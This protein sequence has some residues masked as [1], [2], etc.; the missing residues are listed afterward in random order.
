MG[1]RGSLPR[2][3]ALD[4][5][6]STPGGRVGADASGTVVL[7]GPGNVTI[8][9]RFRRTSNRNWTIEVNGGS[10]SL[11]GVTLTA[12]DFSGRLV[13]VGG[14][15]VGSVRLN[16]SRFPK[17]VSGWGQSSVLRLYYGGSASSRP[18]VVSANG[19]NPADFG[20]T[21]ARWY[22]S[23]SVAA[24]RDGNAVLLQGPVLPNGTYRLNASGNVQFGTNAV[25][26]SGYYASKG[27]GR[28]KRSTWSIQGDGADTVLP[29]G[30]LVEKSWLVINN[31]ERS[32]LGR[33]TVAPILGSP[34]RVNTFVWFLDEHVWTLKALTAT[35]DK[36]T[37]PGIDGL[38]VNTG[39]MS[40]RIASTVAGG[41]VWDLDTS[42]SLQHED[43]A[44][45]GT[46]HATG[47]AQW[48]LKVTKG[49]GSIL[50]VK[51]P[52]TLSPVSGQ[53]SFDAGAIDGRIEIGART[54]LLLNLPD[55]W[56]PTTKL[57]INLAKAN[58]DAPLTKSMDVNYTVRKGRN[59]LTLAGTFE[60]SSVFALD[61]SGELFVNNTA[62]PFGGRFESKGWIHDSAPRTEPYWELSGNI[63]DAAGGRVPMSGG[64]DLVD[65]SFG[66]ASVDRPPLFRENLSPQRQV[67]AVVHILAGYSSGFNGLTQ[68]SFSALDSWTK[69]VTLQYTDDNNWSFTATADVG[70]PWSPPGMT[71]LVIDRNA[72]YGSV[73]DT[74]G[75]YTWNLKIDSVSW[76]GLAT[77]V[78]LTTPMTFSNVCPLTQNCPPAASGQVFVGMP[79]GK[80]TFPAGVPT[81][82]TNGAFLTDGTWARMDATAPTITFSPASISNGTL[83]M[84]K[85]P[86]SDEFDSNLDMPDLSSYNNGFGIE[87]CGS[88]QINVFDIK[89]LS[90]GGCIEW[91]P[92]GWVI[93][94]VNTGGSISTGSSNGVSLN[95]AGLTGFAYTNL[96]I[97]PSIKLGSIPLTLPNGI[98]QLTANLKLP[99][100]LMYAMGKSNVDTT[101]PASGFYNPDS[102]D[103]ALD[104]TVDVNMKNQGFELL[105]INVHIG[106]SGSSYTLGFGADATVSVKGN[107]YPVSAYVGVDAGGGSSGIVVRLSAKG[108]VSSQPSGSFDQPTLLPTGNFEPV[109]GALVDGTFDVKQPASVL[110]NG[111]FENAVAQQ[112]NLSN[113]DFEN[114]TQSELYPDGG[115]EDGGLGSYLNNGDFEDTDQTNNGDFE[116]ND[117]TGWSVRTGFSG[118]L[119]SD[120]APTTELG[121]YAASVK[122]TASTGTTNYSDG[123][124]QYVTV[125]P[126]TNSTYTVGA[127]V[128]SGTAS[129]ARVRLGLYQSQDGGV[130]NSCGTVTASASYGDY[131]TVNSTWQYISMTA[132][133]LSCR[134]S[135]A[136][137]VTIPDGQSTVVFDAVTVAVTQGTASGN[138]P[139]VGTDRPSQTGSGG[140]VSVYSNAANAHSGTGFMAMKGTSSN[141]YAGWQ[142]GEAPVQYGTYTFSAWVRSPTG[143]AVS[144]KLYLYTV[145]GTAENTWANFTT[146]G[147]AW[148]R[149][150]V[151]TQIAL[152]GHTDIQAGF[153]SMTTL[154]TELD[155]DDAVMQ[156]VVTNAYPSVTS[157]YTQAVVGVTTDGSRSHT[158]G[159]NLELQNYAS[160]T[161]GIAI[162]YRDMPA[163]LKGAT[164]RWTAWAMNP[165]STA[166]TAGV[167]LF[168]RSGTNE[169]T[170]SY[171]SRSIKNTDGWVQLSGTMTFQYGDHTSLTLD[172]RNETV[173]STILFDDVS[174]TVVG[175]VRDPD[176]SDAWATVNFEGDTPITNSTPVVY[177]TDYGNPGRSL[178]VNNY[179]DWWLFNNGTDSP[180]YANGDFDASIDVYFPGTTQRDVAKFGFWLTGSGAST[181][182]YEFRVQNST[183]AT[184]SGFHTVNNGKLVRV[185]GDTDFAALVSKVWHRIRLQA[186]GSVVTATITRLDTEAVVYTKTLTMPSGNRSGVFGEPQPGGGATDG[187]RWDNFSGGETKINHWDN[188]ANAHTGNGY[189]ELV[190]SNN[191]ATM[192][193]SSTFTPNVGGTYS[194]SAWVK[195]PSGTVSGSIVAETLGT[196]QYATKNFTANGTW[197]LV[198]A[199]VPITKSGATGI[200]LSLNNTSS[201]ASLWVDDVNI[202][203]AGLTQP[204]P[205]LTTQDLGGFTATKILSDRT[206]AHGGSNYLQ[207]TANN[208]SGSVYRDVPVTLVTGQQYTYEAW[209]RSPTGTAVNG[210]ISLQYSGGTASVDRQANF[211]ATSTWQRVYLTLP[212]GTEANTMVRAKVNVFTT[213]VPLDI[214]D[215]TVTPV[216]IWTDVEN[217]GLAIGQTVVNDRANAAGGSNYLT[218]T[219]Y[220]GGGLYPMDSLPPISKSSGVS[221]SNG[222]LQ[223][224]G[225]GDWWFFNSATAGYVSGDFDMSSDVYWPTPTAGQTA[226]KD[227]VN[228]GF[229]MT[230][231]GSSPTGYVFRVFSGSTDTNAGFYSVSS[232]TATK[233]GDTGFGQLSTGIWYRVR[234][235][236]SGASVT[237]VI[238][239]LDTNAVVRTQTFSMP[240]GN[241]AGVF[242][243]VAGSAA[244]PNGSRFDNVTIY[245]PPASVNAHVTT[246]VAVGSSYSYHAFV[247]STT[248]AP[249]AGQLVLRSQG[250]TD[251]L[252]AVPFVATADWQDVGTTFTATK[253]NSV[254]SPS[255]EL[256]GA[257]QLD[258]DEADLH[259][260]VIVQ[261]DPWVATPGASGTVNAFVYD[262]P[263]NAHDSSG[264]LRVTKTGAN[265]ATVYHDMKTSPATGS[266]Y[267]FTAWVRSPSGSSVSGQLVLYANGG[268]QQ[269][270]SAS[271]T[272]T[273]AWQQVTLLSPSMTSGHT[274]LRAQIVL[275]TSSVELD[276]DDAVVQPASWQ[277]FADTGGTSSQVQINDADLAQSGTGFLRIS[278]TKASDGGV[279]LDTPGSMSTSTTQV[280]TV[281]VRSTDGTNVS[282]RAVLKARGSGSGDDVATQSFTA[283]ADWQQVTVKVP[284][285]KGGQNSLRSMIYVDTANKSLDIDT[286]NVGQDPLGDPDGITTPLPHP[287]SGYAYLWNDAFGIPGAHLWA[288]TA[289]ISYTNGMPGLG[290]GATMYFDPTK[291]SS[292][293]QGTTWLKGDMSVNISAAEPCFAFSFNSSDP[294]TYVGIKG[295]VFK[296][297]NFL[298]S[299]APRGCSI[300]DY[301]LSP[302]SNLVF[303]TSLGDAPIHFELAI[304]RDDN[305]LPTFY[306]NL[307]VSNLK[308]AGI[309]YNQLSLTVDV[310]VGGGSNVTMVGDFTLP[311]GN[312]YGTF[313]LS[314]SDTKLHQAGSVTLTDW[315]MVGGSFDVSLFKFSM[316]MDIPVGAGS[317]AD[318]T[319][320]TEG[321][322]T[323]GKKAYDFNGNMKLVCGQLKVLHFDFLYTKSSVQYHF[324]LDYNSDTHVLAGGLQFKFERSTSWKYLSHRYRRHPK[325]VVRIDFSMDFDKP[326]ADSL[327]IYGYI[328]VSGGSGSLDCSF[329][330][331]GD[332]S[333][334]L[335]VKINVF[336]GHTYKATW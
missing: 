100:T 88:F 155:V 113:S 65:G 313:D 175:L 283:G 86:R 75:V 83:T 256:F 97:K 275:K 36:W 30:V 130:P 291:A 21:T 265:D 308:L 191:T 193:R 244:G 29:G 327:S 254:L 80:L 303:D 82:T 110:A 102:G 138:L 330:G 209:V 61:A 170:G 111:D 246:P 7:R 318:F 192:R 294:N 169:A 46:F 112:T 260:L 310:S 217:V 316:S 41:V 282:G 87:F 127:W 183:T 57:T 116:T 215:L 227:M 231:A 137:L 142:L 10:G 118:S 187:H 180:G 237:A 115:F 40:G 126:V 242:G 189:V 48:N 47:P 272:A 250:G 34:A 4:A 211:T 263:V 71:N 216:G 229:W 64:A 84:W 206:Q 235:T 160:G 122:N 326:A 24:G 300:G 186:V 251:E 152:S 239:R 2:A 323:M 105:D 188:P 279:Q 328:S 249:I 301:T 66:L 315:K 8:N 67:L 106:K 174:V 141:W 98:P 44:L 117:W 146:S 55:G 91:D 200:T 274:S 42:M 224:D 76:T 81:L 182:G 96:S 119:I 45:T 304:G 171:G 37:P 219:A 212:V 167:Q 3:A 202:S 295:G 145:G 147:S 129:T 226:S 241:R 143:T 172:L 25:E 168:G 238:T 333:C 159:G 53:V 109:N 150:S 262:D 140:S 336:G 190:T 255:V 184:D 27:Y 311:M 69:T 201:G 293:M 287:E 74:K 59:H 13:A 176:P 101:I 199:S 297:T 221:L 12:S 233:L 195:A 179:D 108:A 28:A 271:F 319:A 68:L 273:G 153:G 93:G 139:V 198:T 245:N 120:S 6:L 1:L 173:G 292:I 58:I 214:D 230:N 85:G 288:L 60:S 50:G 49:T 280:M 154:N 161:G 322:L 63:K 324:Y 158:G 70:S 181:V 236:A 243:Q 54:A 166:A 259:P 156:T 79:N 225:N 62:I 163:P 270:A 89:T 269:S 103:F 277:T 149:V 72:I 232:G 261:S 157:N 253:T 312:F 131:A 43:V 56:V 302:G 305:G 90:T 286:V 19:A 178:R 135:L 165:S 306:E 264:M 121:N 18:L 185:S 51:S 32:L 16:L 320:A 267:S 35:P 39:A 11:G 125:A 213:G 73:T 268:T 17:L 332:D 128:R 94:Q 335:Y 247:R 197:Q 331:S 177:S 290:V 258:V 296:T 284:V 5:S 299:V 107:H 148:Q 329:G 26:L 95:G 20:T 114:G 9:G 240:S 207:V 307:S 276:V 203:S 218:V 257:G 204:S 210:N 289:Q 281:W 266:L 38:T 223:S 52:V 317:C 31:R 104:G 144:G 132:T 321:N 14:N 325:F 309:T 162:G 298:I 220:G 278:D 248:G 314:M 33:A 23:I 205:F 92:A 196:G 234:L 134:S 77:G 285:S 78:N 15:V 151:T 133:A 252:V 22:G 228:L 124:V 164:Y 123:F 136:I 99:G 208:A 222:Q 194:V 334:S